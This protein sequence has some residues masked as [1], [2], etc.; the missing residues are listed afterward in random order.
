MDLWS[1]SGSFRWL[2][3]GK[4]DPKAIYGLPPTHTES[5]TGGYMDIILDP[6]YEENGWV[7][8]S[9]SHTNQGMTDPEAPALTKIVRG[10]INDY[11]WTDQQTLFEVPDSLMVVKGNRW[12][13]RFLF[14]QE[15]YL[16]FTIGDMARAMDL[17][18]PTNG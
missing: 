18:D 1:R 7:Y 11:Q 12:G 15:G 3:D 14:D 4:L 6:D 5:S 17:Q 10:K 16:H 2:V 9:Y 8:L 13:C